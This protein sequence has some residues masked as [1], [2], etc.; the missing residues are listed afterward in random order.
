MS[1]FD[2]SVRGVDVDPDTRCAHYHTDRDVVA[3]KFACCETYWPCFRCHE[4][5]ADHDAVPWPRARF[6][7]PTVLC[8]VCRTELT[9]PAYREADYRCPSCNV[10]FNPGC[11]AHAD[12][13]FETD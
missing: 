6:D 8:G 9:V 10:A 1:E 2:H 7:E 5:I 13:Y 11:A 4:E 3:F 12:L